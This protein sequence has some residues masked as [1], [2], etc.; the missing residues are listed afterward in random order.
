MDLLNNIKTRFWSED[1]WLPKGITWDLLK[2][3]ETRQYGQCRDLVVIFPITLLIFC[4]RMILEKSIA[5]PIGRR[6]N[7]PD[8][9]HKAPQDNIILEKVFKTITKSP[10]KKQLDGLCKQLD[11]N[12]RQV[13]L[14]F[15]MRGLSGRPSTLQKFSEEFWRFTF[16]LVSFLYGLYVLHDEECVFNRDKCW[17]DFP[18]NHAMTT[19]MYWYYIIQIGFYTSTTLTQFFDVKRKDF[20][21]MFIHHIAT[22]LLLL[23]SYIMNFT[24][25]GSFI[26]LVHDSA[27]FYLEFA[28]MAKY[29][30]YKQTTNVSFGC[31]ALAFLVSRLIILPFWIIP[32]IWDGGMGSFLPYSV[33]HYL[34]PFLLTLQ[35][36]HFYWGWH[37]SYAVYS[38]IVVGEIKRDTR[39]DTEEESDNE[40][41]KKHGTN[42]NKRTNHIAG[43]ESNGIHK[44]VTSTK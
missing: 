8:K 41:E 32:A 35:V 14:W 27:D 36:L 2:N 23:G 22:I 10:N 1:F 37:V 29:A 26:V 15:R 6:L 25:M 7:L 12:E 18:G 4:I 40:N 5:Q 43:G 28:K 34:F 20:W 44:R 19:K 42:G 30:K 21:E 11:W 33:I 3:T 38:S 24:K 16:Y 9:A 17:S 13:S 39:S 31:F